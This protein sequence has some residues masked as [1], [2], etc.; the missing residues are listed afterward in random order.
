MTIQAYPIWGFDS[1]CAD[2]ERHAFISTD[3]AVVFGNL[4]HFSKILP[5]GT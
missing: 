5:K 1:G 2:F 3:I 4:C